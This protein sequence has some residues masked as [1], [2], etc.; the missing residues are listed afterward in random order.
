METLSRKLAKLLGNQTTRES[1]NPREQPLPDGN[2]T[3]AAE[4]QPLPPPAISEAHIA[5]FPRTVLDDPDLTDA[6][7]GRFVACLWDAIT[8]QGEKMEFLLNAGATVATLAR[9]FPRN[10]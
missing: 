1:P 5:A 9:L 7:K 3:G 6:E 10:A 8:I 2:A 4:A